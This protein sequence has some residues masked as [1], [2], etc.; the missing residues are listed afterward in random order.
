M[1]QK[2]VSE[3]RSRLR[4]LSAHLLK[5]IYQPGR[6]TRSLA[7]TIL[8]QRIAIA[9]HIDDNPSLRLKLAEAFAKAYTDGREL[10]VAET[11]LPL[12]TFPVDPSLGSD[13]ALSQSWV[14]P[15]VTSGTNGSVEHPG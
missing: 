2:E 15:A 3:L 9:D 4:I 14:P 13:E 6:S 8:D 12:D 10:A 5:Q 7:T 11:G 1:G